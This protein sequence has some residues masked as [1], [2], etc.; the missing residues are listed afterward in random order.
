MAYGLELFAKQH[1][2]IQIK[3]EPLPPGFLGEK[4]P[5][6]MAAGTA[7]DL[8][9]FSGNEVRT[10][11]EDLVVLDDYAA[12]LGINLDDYLI[13]WRQ[14]P[15]KVDLE[16]LTLNGRLYMCPFFDAVSGHVFNINLFESAGL[17]A[18]TVDWTWDNYIDSA[19]QLTDADKDQFGTYHRNGKEFDWL[20]RISQNGAWL[21]SDKDR[22][23]QGVGFDNEGGM[24][25]FEWYMNAIHDLKIAPAPEQITGLATE[26]ITDPFA[27]GKVG[28]Y[29]TGI[30][31]PGSREN[32]IKDRFVWDNMPDPMSPLGKRAYSTHEIGQAIPRFSVS[33]GTVEDAVELGF[34]I[35]GEEFQQLVAQWRGAMPVHKKI[36][37]SD[38]WLKPIA[39]RFL[40]Q[41]MSLLGDNIQSQEN[42]GLHYWDGWREW[43]AVLGREVEPAWIGEKSP[44]E[45]LER[46]V[47]ESNRFI[48][49]VRERA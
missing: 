4:V 27:A 12:K 43:W 13:L 17:P 40:P 35:G 16:Y 24:A 39:G 6:M 10:F 3:T 31:S 9:L 18:P 29:P 15:E 14:Q 34:F 49:S 1:P 44:R 25:A 28:M 33:R 19:K 20:P 2:Y 8:F 21:F 22:P 11:Y 48:A 26:G 42:Y 36:L 5:V 38:A 47:Q 23:P 30:H 37:A 46:A 32:Q 41:T 7:P 45:A